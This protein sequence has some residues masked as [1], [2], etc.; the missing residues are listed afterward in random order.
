[1]TAKRVALSLLAHPDDAEFLCAGTLARL[2]ANGWEIH[3]ATMTPG[4]CGSATLGPEEISAIRRREGAA[5]AAVLNGAFHCLEARDGLIR[6]DAETMRKAVKL[7]R[8]IRPGLMFAHS[9][10]CYLYDHEAASLIARDAAFWSGVP[11][12]TTPGAQPFRPMPHLYYADAMEGKD[13]FGRPVEPG[14]LVDISSTMPVKR[15]MLCCHASQRE[16]LRQHHGMD[17][18]VRAMEALG[19]VRGGQAGCEFAE[20]FRQHLGHAYPQ[21]DLLARELGGLVY[22]RG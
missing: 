4:D 7:V 6:H 11:N 22:P 19:R 1:M 8:E 2:H 15:E 13:L 10:S 14:L 18:Y 16:W 21:D 17:E 20:G 3:L 5:A 12:F 9:P